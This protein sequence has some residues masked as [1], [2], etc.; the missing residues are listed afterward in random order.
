[1]NGRC[2]ELAELLALRVLGALGPEEEARVARHLESGC[3]RCVAELAAASETLALLPYAL[4]EVQPS[5][6]AKA[7]LMARVRAEARTEPP[8]PAVKPASATA[9]WWRVAAAAAIASLLSIY[10]TGTY[11]AKKSGSEMAA[12][13]RQLASQSAE[14]ANLQKQVFQARDAIRMASAPGVHVLDLA[15]QQALQAS[16]ARVFWDPKSTSWQ[17]YAANLPAPPPGKTYQLWLITPTA[18]ISAGTFTNEGTGQVV[19]PADAGAVVAVAVTDEPE[20]GSPQPTGSILLLG[21][22]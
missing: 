3:P 7:R 8:V 9:V 1:M 5:E 13:R 19:V 18:K 17:L 11:L 2:D 20:G 14:L 15:G 16:S 12:L 22:I 21:K 4:P 6:S 10:G